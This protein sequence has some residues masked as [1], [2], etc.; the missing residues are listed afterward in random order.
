MVWLLLARTYPL[1]ANWGARINTRS[2]NGTLLTESPNGPKKLK[3][4]SSQCLP[5][6]VPVR[7]PFKPPPPLFSVAAGLVLPRTCVFPAST[8]LLLDNGPGWTTSQDRRSRSNRSDVVN[9]TLVLSC[10]HLYYSVCCDMW[11]QP[12]LTPVGQAMVSLIWLRDMNS[13]YGVKEWSR[14]NRPR[15]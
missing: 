14:H 6:L 9:K 13:A 7:L 15:I 11:L 10:F 12:L 3:L 8:V 1:S 4:S 2:K 5:K